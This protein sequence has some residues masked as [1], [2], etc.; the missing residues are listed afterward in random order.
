MKTTYRIRWKVSRLRR[1]KRTGALQPV[2]QSN[3]AKYLET[4]SIKE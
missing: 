2:K 4:K 3:Y 1:D